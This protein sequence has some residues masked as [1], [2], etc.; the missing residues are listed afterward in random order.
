[1]TRR[2]IRQLW[3]ASDGSAIVE[4][5]ILGPVM[6]GMMFA[7]LQIGIGMQNYNALRGIAADTARYSVVN[8]QSG[9]KLSTTQLSTF[10][11]STATRPPYGLI[12]SRLTATVELA[13][14]QRVTGATELTVSLTYQVPTALSVL[15]MGDIPIQYSRPVFLLN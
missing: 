14:T 3:R 10:A 11:R 6:L 15:S 5:A 13:G 4:F 2:S 7:V 1:M 12:G 9:N 8:Y